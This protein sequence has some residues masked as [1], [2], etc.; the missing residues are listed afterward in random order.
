MIPRRPTPGLDMLDSLPQQ[1]T[2]IDSDTTTVSVRQTSAQML[3]AGSRSSQS[4]SH[5][6]RWVV[7][8]QDMEKIEVWSVGE[9]VVS[10]RE[11]LALGRMLEGGVAARESGYM[12][13]RNTG[14]LKWQTM[15]DRP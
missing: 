3:L 4:V 13:F 5:A 6:G 2:R 10:G 7:Y 11:P 9:Y 1:E 12:R 8:I 14:M 15:S